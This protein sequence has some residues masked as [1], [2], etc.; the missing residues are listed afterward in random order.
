MSV[1]PHRT[2]RMRRS[3]THREIRGL[4]MLKIGISPTRTC[5]RTLA[6]CVL[7]DLTRKAPVRKRKQR[8]RAAHSFQN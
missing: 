3:L 6:T 7:F 4:A 5:S 8:L 1:D 2:A